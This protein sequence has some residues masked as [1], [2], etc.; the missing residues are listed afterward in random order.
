MNGLLLCHGGLKEFS[1]FSLKAEQT[2]AYRGNYGTPLSAETARALVQ[3]LLDN[4]LVSDH[5]IGLQVMGYKPQDP[6]EGPGNFRPDLN[7][8]GDNELLC[9]MMNMATRRWVKLDANWRSTLSEI[10][11]N[12][13]SPLWLN[14]LCCSNL[15]D[16]NVPEAAV[17]PTLRVK[18]WGSILK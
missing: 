12:L 4:P 7:L 18:D 8:R 3:A 14:L 2:V 6:L 15:N 1:A 17:D 16:V 5:E 9:F 13:G 10:C 11:L